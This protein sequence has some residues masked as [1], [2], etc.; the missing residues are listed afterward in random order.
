[1]RIE[2]DILEDWRRHLSQFEILCEEYKTD[3]PTRITHVANSVNPSSNAYYFSQKLRKVD[4]PWK[5]MTEKLD[6]M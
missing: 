6:S 1:M 4:K 2:E 3:N 5:E